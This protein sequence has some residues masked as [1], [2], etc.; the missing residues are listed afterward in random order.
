[1]AALNKYYRAITYEEYMDKWDLPT[2]QNA[3]A[4]S[5]FPEHV[6]LWIWPKEQKPFAIW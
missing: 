3:V 6:E 5:E 1:L 2:T 4:V